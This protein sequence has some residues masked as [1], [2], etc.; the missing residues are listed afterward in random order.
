M[1]VERRTGKVRQ[2]QTVPRNQPFVIDSSWLNFLA[3]NFVIL[4]P[5]SFTLSFKFLNVCT[6][7]RAL[8]STRRHTV[9]RRYAY[10]DFCCSLGCGVILTSVWG[11]EVGGTCKVTGLKIFARVTNDSRDP[12]VFVY[13]LAGNLLRVSTN[14]VSLYRCLAFPAPCRATRSTPLV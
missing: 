11:A 1:Q 13:V 9:V 6:G 4:P 3:P 2:S 8:M 12:I 7:Y 10:I 14:H 5:Y